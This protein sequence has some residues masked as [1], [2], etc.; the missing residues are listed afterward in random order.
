MFSNKSL[1]QKSIPERSEENA[2]QFIYSAL[3]SLEKQL[4]RYIQIYPEKSYEMIKRIDRI[5]Q[6]LE[7]VMD[8]LKSIH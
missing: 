8:E 4:P 1:L 3:M 2:E 7:K 6:K 5:L